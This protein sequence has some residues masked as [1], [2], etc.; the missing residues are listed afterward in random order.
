MALLMVHTPMLSV[1]CVEPERNIQEIRT[2][3][4][5]LVSPVVT[6]IHRPQLHHSV[7]AVLNPAKQHQTV[8]QLV[9]LAKGV[10]TRTER[11]PI[12]MPV[13]SARKDFLLQGQ[14][15]CVCRVYRGNF[16]P[17]I[18]HFQRVVTFVQLVNITNRRFFVEIVSMANTKINT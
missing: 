4:V 7:K 16:N 9:F 5:K 15:H 11:R 8:S 2:I 14:Q 6:K 18:P 1:P 10:N 13:N 3:R 12:R 17:T